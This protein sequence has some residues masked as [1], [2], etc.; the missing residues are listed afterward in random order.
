MKKKKAIGLISGGL[1][2]ILSLKIIQE[3]NIEV[4][5]VYILTPFMSGFGEKTIK[6][7]KRLEKTPGFQLKIIKTDKDYL[8]IVKNPEF[9]YGKNLNP[10]IDCHI[11]MLKKAKEIMEEEKAEFVFT[12]E[13][14][15]Q[16]RKSQ[17]M[18]PLRIV[19]EKSSLKNRLVRPLSA[20]FLP[21]TEPEEKGIL[22]RN[23][24]LGLKG[25]ERKL[26]L[27]LAEEKD[28]K[29][30]GSP[31]G[32]CLLTDSQFCKRLK[33]L[34]H[35]KKDINI[36]DCLFLQVGRHFQVSTDTRLIISRNEK[37]KDK[38][39]E[40]V[41][42]GDFVITSPDS[43]ELFG[44]VKG[45]VSE[46]AFR[47]LASYAQKRSSIIEV[48]DFKGNIIEKKVVLK[49]NKLQFHKLLI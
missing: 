3:Q 46:I 33:S 40:F 34:F 27:Y 28:L 21:P 14:L 35:H 38:M 39:N 17:T 1:D 24:L 12:G 26:Q 5:G 22:D 42:N 18:T 15:N 29:Y 13:V 30:Y 9:G 48:K 47:I 37:E 43:L 23:K 32:G 49:E 36:N 31:A 2:S 6:N 44:I 4:I 19:E 8:D 11:Y 45:K 20:L 16:R 25:R 10:C 7:L 41:E